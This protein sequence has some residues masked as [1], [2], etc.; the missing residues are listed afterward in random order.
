MDMG[1]YVIIINA[2]KVAVTGNKE[3]DKT[4]FRHTSNKRSGAGKP[5]GW[6]LETLQSLRNRLPERILEEAVRGMLPK[7][8]L[9]KGL[10]VHHL[11]VFKGSEHPHASQS[12][13]DITPLIDA[14]PSP[15]FQ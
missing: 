15:R 7:G 11:K 13:V 5:G 1:S 4:Y 2:D 9:G 6:K 10:R 3:T 14:K 8:R 12:P